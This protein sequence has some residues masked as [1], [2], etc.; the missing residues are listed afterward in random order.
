MNSIQEKIDAIKFEKVFKTICSYLIR[1]P[2]YKP[3]KV[4]RDI[5]D[6][7]LA[8]DE[9]NELLYVEDD[10]RLGHIVYVMSAICLFIIYTGHGLYGLLIEMD[11]ERPENNPVQVGDNLV[12]F[13]CM[14]TNCT[15]LSDNSQST[16]AEEFLSLPR[17]S[18]C[19]KKLRYFIFFAMDLGKNGK[20]LTT[21]FGIGY[22]Y[23]SFPL[24]MQML[25]PIGDSTM[26]FAIAP[27]YSN[28]ILMKKIEHILNDILISLLTFRTNTMK[29]IVKTK[30]MRIYEQ[31]KLAKLSQEFDHQR[32]AKMLLMSQYRHNN[33]E[34]DCQELDEYI[35]DC[36]PISR[37]DWWHKH[38]KLFYK[39]C[40]IFLPFNI[41]L[42][43]IVNISMMTF[44]GFQEMKNFVDYG[45]YV[46]SNGCSIRI[47]AGSDHT[48]T[49]N[50]FIDRH[51]SI[52]QL[53]QNELNM[54]IFG[55]LQYIIIASLG[56]MIFQITLMNFI[57]LMKDLLSWTSELNLQ[58]DFSIEFLRLKIMLDRRIDTRDQEDP[59]KLKL[60]KHQD[61]IININRDISIIGHITNNLTNI[62]ILSSRGSI[63]LKNK[64]YH[65]KL[66]LDWLSDQLE[67]NGQTSIV[68]ILEKVYIKFRLLYDVKDEYGASLTCLLLY[69]GILAYLLSFV[70]LILTRNFDNFPM[71]FLFAFAFLLGLNTII[72]AAAHFKTSVSLLRGCDCKSI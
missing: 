14:I 25:R 18:I 42:T 20:F 31:D 71:P 44:W 46:K 34:Y 45:K 55:W 27:Q 40:T 26:M 65:Q 57:N 9:A 16:L 56:I 6:F 3:N 10:K 28:K 4:H 11:Y 22:F 67:S 54:S 7:N 51:E 63:N 69:N 48:Q 23:S 72:L 66:A 21:V 35:N 60:K 5:R 68:E 17:I 58:M 33:L 24:M 49:G 53:D 15:R 37:S 62:S 39:T 8:T 59:I 29:H 52:V 19:H 36:M 1:Y 43:L 50:E 41:A 2:S 13:S 32:E 38:V 61:I 70:L 47:N 30:P 12:K 64:I